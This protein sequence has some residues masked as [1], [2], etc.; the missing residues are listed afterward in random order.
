MGEYYIDASLFYESFSENQVRQH[1]VIKGDVI[2]EV[3]II[4]K[5]CASI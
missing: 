3:V 5:S 4:I 1:D 2:K